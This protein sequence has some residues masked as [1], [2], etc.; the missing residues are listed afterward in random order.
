M[1]TTTD[2]ALLQGIAIAAALA[3]ANKRKPQREEYL[4]KLQRKV[5]PK[6]IKKAQLVEAI[7]AQ[8]AVK[9]RAKKAA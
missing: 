3:L 7:E 2:N 8:E 1:T 9:P 4:A 5:T 6:G